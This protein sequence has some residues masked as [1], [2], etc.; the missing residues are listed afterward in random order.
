KIAADMAA[1]GGYITE[2]DLANYQTLD[3]RYI[4]IDYRGYQIHTI[5]A[6]AGGGLIVKSLNIMEQFNLSSLSDPAWAA[7]V[8]QALA[9][10]I[11]SMGYDYEEADLNQV[12]SKD[13]ARQQVQRITVPQITTTDESYNNNEQATFAEQQ[14]QYLAQENNRG[15]H[16]EQ[17]T[18]TDW[19]SDSWGADSHHTTHF[20]T[21]DCNGMAVSITQTVGPL[22]G[23]KVI[24]P[25]LGFV[26]AS[27]M[28]TY[29]SAAA[30]DPGARPR[31]TIAPTMVTRN[32][33][34]EL[35]LGA[36]GG[37]RIL[38][39][40][41]QTLSR[42]IDRGMTLEQAVAAPRIHPEVETDTTTGT[43]TIKPK[44]IHAETTPR[45]G[46]SQANIAAWEAAGFEIEANDSYGAFSR[47]H[48]LAQPQ[49]GTWQGAADLDWEG[50]A[51]APAT[52][53]CNR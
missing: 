42:Y 24:S 40:I 3:G 15:Q 25:E 46:W 11:E 53:A 6:P 52:S 34:L 37:L 8:N 50:T 7:V 13:W 10:A 23:S 2:A 19:T 36:A 45:N 16:H 12:T 4:S 41:V 44:Y 48:A 30:Q 14:L 18:L 21:A 38:S 28:G 20:V 31:T 26:Y 39:G 49:P 1:N 35:V 5:A 32:G 27:T 9:I 33:E 29:L 43:R 51:S 17:T 47:I 22:F